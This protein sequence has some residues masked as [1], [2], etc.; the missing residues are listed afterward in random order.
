MK[1][2]MVLLDK[3]DAAEIK[4]AISIYRKHNNII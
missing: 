4:K 1:Y 2:I 3:Y